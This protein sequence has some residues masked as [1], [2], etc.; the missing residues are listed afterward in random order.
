M[1]LNI[2]LR[3]D[4]TVIRQAEIIGSIADKD[5]LLALIEEAMPDPIGALAKLRAT[6]AT[7][8]DGS[9]DKAGR[10]LSELLDHLEQTASKADASTR[11]DETAKLYAVALKWALPY[12]RKYLAELSTA[13]VASEG[14]SHE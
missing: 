12:M 13:P 9:W 4:G 5:S 1:I 3:A 2:K 6:P 10:K 7:P 14:T 11:W 8:V